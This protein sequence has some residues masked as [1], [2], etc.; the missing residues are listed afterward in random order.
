M[1][2]SFLGQI[3]LCI[4]AMFIAERMITNAVNQ[5]IDMIWPLCGVI[6]GGIMWVTCTKKLNISQA[7]TFF[8]FVYV[9]AMMY[10]T[11]AH[12]KTKGNDGDVKDLWSSIDVNSE[13][14][15]NSTHPV[16]KPFCQMQII[17]A[18]KLPLSRR[19]GRYVD[20]YDAESLIRTTDFNKKLE[21]AFKLFFSVQSSATFCEKVADL[22]ATV[23]SCTEV[24]QKQ[25]L[26]QNR[27][28]FALVVWILL[29]CADTCYRSFF[30]PIVADAE[31][32]E[33]DEPIPSAVLEKESEQDGCQP[34]LNFRPAPQAPRPAVPSENGKD[35]LYSHVSSAHDDNGK[36]PTH[37]PKKNATA[38]SEVLATSKGV[39]VISRGGSSTSE[40]GTDL[41]LGCGV[42]GL[43][44]FKDQCEPDPD[45][46]KGTT[47]KRSGKRKSV[48]RSATPVVGVLIIP[49]VVKR[50]REIEGG[51]E[52]E[53][54]K[55]QA[56]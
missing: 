11:D 8:V 41:N 9:F 32:E 48:A 7:I 3:V 40:T 37:G 42:P 20:W 30:V 6:F 49:E 55:V 33:P 22:Q 10:I 35:A 46:P 4:S 52:W 54:N 17:Y 28:T 51:D 19:T 27:T 12:P 26:I 50:P 47:G 21:E 39:A 44:L 56:V 36:K 16:A 45:V 18:E 53:S 13:W 1:I 14:S 34:P 15:C 23:K 5:L 29:C 24:S 2:L 38:S 25:L 31:K 43:R